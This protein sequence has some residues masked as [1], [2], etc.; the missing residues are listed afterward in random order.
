MT[1]NDRSLESTGLKIVD[2]RPN[3][4]TNFDPD[5]VSLNK[6]ASFDPLDVGDEGSQQGPSPWQIECSHNAVV[7]VVHLVARQLAD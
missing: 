5:M 7:Y 4:G 6:V 3:M 2:S 1:G